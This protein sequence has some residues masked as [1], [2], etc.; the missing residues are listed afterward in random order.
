MDKTG[1]IV[2]GAGLAMCMITPTHHQ[3]LSHGWV[4][5][6]VHPVQGAV[7]SMHRE[8]DG[9]V[10]DGVWSMQPRQVGDTLKEV[11]RL[12][13][14]VAE[15][16][17]RVAMA[18]ERADVKTG[19]AAVS[20]AAWWAGET[21]Q[22][23]QATFAAMRLAKAL[24]W[25]H[26][27]VRDA[28]AA[29]ELVVEQAEVIVR[30]VDALTTREAR[31]LVEPAVVAAA[32][33]ELIRLA[34]DYDAKALRVLGRRILDVVAPEV[35]EAH[36]ARQLAKEEQDALASTRF[37][38]REDGLGA[39]HGRFTIPATHAAM[40]RKHLMALAAPFG[41]P[42]RDDGPVPDGEIPGREPL[43]GPKQLGKAFVAYLE[44]Y[45]TDRLPSAG[46]IAADVMVTVGLDTL[47]TGLGSAQLDTGAVISPAMAR[48]L[49]CEAHIIPMVLGG[50]SVVLD[51][52]RKRRFHTRAQRRAIVVQQ[53]HCTADGCDYPPGLCHV[54][55]DVPWAKG[56]TTNVQDARLLC[57]KHHHRAHDPDYTTTKLPGG[58]V[59][60][61]RRT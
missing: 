40:L 1:L 42:R 15:L 22:T 61:T 52:G 19:D 16:E 39:A 8:L 10:D 21:R 46:G 58:G 18:A 32:E 23:R 27:P 36:E 59:R 26:E 50:D 55:H 45:P 28:L 30:A 31:E 25:D 47:R 4:G 51:S 49:A 17:L 11:T 20:T 14:R 38:I 6:C 5:D 12:K 37:T 53:G 7:A 60:F 44:R 29:G 3:V 9:V 54:H 24:D 43:F 33:R 48:M 41:K 57:P 13:A 34:R 35:G 56:G 2:G